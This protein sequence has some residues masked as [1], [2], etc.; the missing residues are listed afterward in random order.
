V[1]QK[2]RQTEKVRHRAERQ[3]DGEN[4][5]QTYERRK[6]RT[7]NGGEKEKEKKEGIKKQKP[8]HSYKVGEKRWRQKR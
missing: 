4:E 6:R 5:N 3:T 1:R 8:R 7:E 2:D